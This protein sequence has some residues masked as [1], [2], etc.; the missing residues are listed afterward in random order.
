[1][2]HTPPGTFFP[3]MTV[4]E[5]EITIPYSDLPGLTRTKAKIDTGDGREVVKALIEKVLTV[6]ADLPSDSRPLGFVISKSNPVGS[7]ADQVTQGYSLSF[8]YTYDTSE[9][10]L[11]PEPDAPAPIPAG[12]VV[13]GL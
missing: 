5:T 3:N 10:T 7:G 9:V 4:T 2:A 13:V 8:T 12:S 6:F 11:L 1:M